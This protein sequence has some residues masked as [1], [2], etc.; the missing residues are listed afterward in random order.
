MDKAKLPGWIAGHRNPVCTIVLILF[1]L[2]FLFTGYRLATG[3]NAYFAG[4]TLSQD[5]YRAK[6]LTASDVHLESTTYGCLLYTSRGKDSNRA[7]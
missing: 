6:V 2:I 5:Y 1:S 3:D 4:Q 7:G